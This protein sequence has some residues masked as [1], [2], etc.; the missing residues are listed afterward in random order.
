MD[1]IITVKNFKL[2]YPK[3]KSKQEISANGYAKLCAICKA[4]NRPNYQPN[5]ENSREPK[6]KT[7]WYYKAGSGFV[8]YFSYSICGCTNALGG[9]LLDCETRELAEHLATF[10]TEWREYLEGK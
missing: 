1:K 6:W 8:F 10:K 5:Y 4:I 7:V 9:P 2:P 3:A